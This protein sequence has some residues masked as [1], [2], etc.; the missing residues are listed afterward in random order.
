LV[1]VLLELI[2]D[3][4]YMGRYV[5]M[6]WNL[7][8]WPGICRHFYMNW[9][10]TRYWQT[11]LNKLKPD[12]VLADIFTWTGTWPGI[13]RHFYMKPNKVWAD[14]FTWTET[15]PGIGRHYINWNLTGYWQTFYM[16]WNLTRYWQ[17]YLHELNLTRYWQ[18]YLHELKSDQVLANIFT[19]TETWPGI[20]RHDIF[21]YSK[22][23]NG[24]VTG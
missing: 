21:T 8:I 14:I 16:N 19:W 12:Q 1:I 6:D 10:L 18:T 4:I 23:I 17:T 7:I 5:Y 9:N 24:N 13:G 11:Y 20:G 15:W 22:L 2:P 3:Q